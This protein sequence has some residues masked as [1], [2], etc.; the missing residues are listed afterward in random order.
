MN[1]SEK[2]SHEFNSNDDSINWKNKKNSVNE[3]DK[4]EYW[5][6]SVAKYH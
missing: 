3:S 4:Q 2:S 5:P 1:P 6:E